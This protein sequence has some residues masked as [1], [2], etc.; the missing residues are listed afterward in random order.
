M[1]KI[2][3]F[4]FIDGFIMVAKEEVWPKLYCQFFMGVIPQELETTTEASENGIPC[5]RSD[6]DM[7]FY[8]QNKPNSPDQEVR[9]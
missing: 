8:V 3:L 5:H 1:I 6:D 7:L 2:T 9:M 4:L